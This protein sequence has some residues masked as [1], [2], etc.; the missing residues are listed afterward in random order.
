MHKE[1]WNNLA[2]NWCIKDGNEGST[3]R[4]LKSERVNK[5]VRSCEDRLTENNRRE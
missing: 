2:I 4:N 3:E 1:T 5:R